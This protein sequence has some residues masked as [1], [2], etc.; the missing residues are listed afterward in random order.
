MWISPGVP[1]R[2]RVPQEVRLLQGRRPTRFWERRPNFLCMPSDRRKAHATNEC[3]ANAP[4][5]VGEHKA[6]HGTDYGCCSARPTRLM[7]QTRS[8][9]KVFRSR[10]RG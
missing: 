10:V 9:R 7:K 1:E 8:A 3:S 5:T 6:S 4:K 2:D